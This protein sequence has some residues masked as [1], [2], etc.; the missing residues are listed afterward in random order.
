MELGKENYRQSAVAADVLAGRVL[1]S[2][3]SLGPSLHV[4]GAWKA[5]CYSVARYA[6][7]RM[8]SEGTSAT[9]A[10]W[11]AAI[12]STACGYVEVRRGSSHRFR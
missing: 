4:H 12:Y 9:V 6:A 11:E 5:S 2:A 1:D 8:D 10:T 7:D 3:A